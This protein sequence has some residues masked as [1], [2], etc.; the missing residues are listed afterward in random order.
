M[1]VNVGNRTPSKYEYM[2]VYYKVHDDA[3][4]LCSNLFGV[5]DEKEIKKNRIYLETMHS[6]VL[7][8]IMELGNYINL[9]TYMN[10]ENHEQY[11]KRRTY[12]AIAI[13]LCH[14]LLALYQHAMKDLHIKGNKYTNEVRDL[15]NLIK[16]L[17][18]W[19]DE[20]ENIYGPII[21]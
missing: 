10:P 2:N 11:L 9:S 3:V 5:E 20:D 4:E 8:L 17:T 7:D 14:A 6:K 21:G 18:E 19:Q 15:I 1:S 12:Q 16:R 13:A